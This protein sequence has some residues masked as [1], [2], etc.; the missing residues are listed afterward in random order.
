[1]AD[2]TVYHAYTTKYDGRSQKLINDVQVAHKEKICDA[3]ALWDTG[4]TGTCVSEELVNELGL[5]P[6]GKLNISTPSGS[7]IVNTYSVDILFPN[8]VVIKDVVVCGT[9]IGEQGI[10]VLIGMDII[11]LGDFS[12]SN[13]EGKTTFSFRIPSKTETDY[14][15][16]INRENLIGPKHGKGK[17]K[18]KRK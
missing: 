1:M 3:T 8:K 14:V 4:A 16:E 7:S 6:T 9:K 13:F 11:T 15:K 18:K 10:Q 17:R 2:N 5:I 12:V